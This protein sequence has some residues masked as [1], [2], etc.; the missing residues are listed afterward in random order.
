MLLLLTFE[1]PNFQQ[2]VSVSFPRTQIVYELDRRKPPAEDSWFESLS[3]CCNDKF[4]CAKMLGME[5]GGNKF[6]PKIRIIG[7]Q[8]VK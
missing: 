3:P 1:F 4:S 5:A 7:L 6:L 2:D 8:R